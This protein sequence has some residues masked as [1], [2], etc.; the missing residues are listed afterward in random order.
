MSSFTTSP[1]RVGKGREYLEIALGVHI[2]EAMIYKAGLPLF[3]AFSFQDIKVGY[4]G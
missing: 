3:N 4:F 1:V 2:V